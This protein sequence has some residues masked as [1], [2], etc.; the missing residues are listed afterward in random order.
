MGFCVRSDRVREPARH[1]DAPLLFTGDD[2][3][4]TDMKPAVAG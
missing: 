1:L 2:F 3:S 4:K